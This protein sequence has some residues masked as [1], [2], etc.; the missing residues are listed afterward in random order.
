LPF[1]FMGRPNELEIAHQA[2]NR[3]GQDGAHRSRPQ[4]PIQRVT[5]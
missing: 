4:A 2:M 3:F 1:R 5:R